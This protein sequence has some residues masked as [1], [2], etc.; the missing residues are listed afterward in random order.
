M[1]YRGVYENR[2]PHN[3]MDK[4]PFSLITLPFCVYIPMSTRQDVQP[5]V[6]PHANCRVQ[7]C[8]GCAEKR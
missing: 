3:P 7:G 4:H 8:P 2:G 6:G 5:R 1:D